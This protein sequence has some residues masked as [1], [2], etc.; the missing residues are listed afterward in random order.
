MN[1]RPITVSGIILI[2][3]NTAEAFDYF[4]NPENDVHWRTEINQSKL[5]GPLQ[6]GVMVEEYS[7]LSKKASNNLI[8]F[9]CIELR[10]D[11]IA[12]FET[13]KNSKFYLR[14]ERKVRVIGENETE[15]Q[16]H[17][18]FDLEIVKYA[19]GFSLPKWLIQW[20]AKSDMKKY[21]RKLKSILEENQ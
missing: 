19:L 8:T 15:I 7:F 2:R 5:L 13:P 21:L 12:L 6:P 9:Q 1:H 14:S 11:Q 20:K 3:K 17:L 16:Y 10:K 4:A 18:T